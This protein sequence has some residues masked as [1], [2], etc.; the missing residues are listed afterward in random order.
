MP[1]GESST[2]TQLDRVVLRATPLF[3]RLGD[4]VFEQLVRSAL[5]L[6]PS[7]KAVVFR[8]GDAATDIY[9]VI[10][11]WLKLYRMTSA[12]QEAI[13]NI[14]TRGRTIAEAVALTHSR[15]P[16]TA[17]ALTDSRLVRLPTR[18][19]VEAMQA[20]P[21]IALSMLASVS[22]HLH[23][24]VAEIARLKGQNGLARVVE[25]LIFIDGGGEHRDLRLPFEK[26]VLARHLAMQPESLSRT[27][28]RL[29][30][31]GVSVEGQTV[32]IQSWDALRR[33]VSDDVG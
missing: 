9:I 27:L 4:D 23:G 12:G 19:M 22:A 1:R 31:Y 20:N 30:A 7:A 18:A 33:A 16:A 8:E 24:L 21:D 29:R 25:F 6:K 32:R 2:L 26:Q 28:R 11:G 14:F 13:I 15:Y 5:V 10:E 17:E 3:Q